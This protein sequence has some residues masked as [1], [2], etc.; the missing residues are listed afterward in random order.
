MQNAKNSMTFKAMTTFNQWQLRPL[1]CM[2]SPLPLP[3]LSG[4]AKKLD[5]SSD[6][7]KHR[8]LQQHLSLAVVRENAASIFKWKKWL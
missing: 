7:K 6:P 2:A 4:L 1:V 3:F 5:V 8:W